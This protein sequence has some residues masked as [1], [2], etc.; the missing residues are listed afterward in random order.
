MTNHREVE[1]LDAGFNAISQKM[2]HHCPWFTSDSV[3][4]AASRDCSTILGTEGNTALE[5]AC[6]LQS[7]RCCLEFALLVGVEVCDISPDKA[8]HALVPDE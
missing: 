3:P 8:I 2:L 4:L 5:Q 7:C 6:F 1:K